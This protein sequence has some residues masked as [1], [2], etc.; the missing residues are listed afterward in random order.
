MLTL[1]CISATSLLV[2]FSVSYLIVATKDQHL[3]FTGDHCDASH[4]KLHSGSVPRVG[5]LSIAAGLLMAWVWMF[6]A[7]GEWGLTVLRLYGCLLPV[8]VAGFIEDLTGLVSPRERF[9]AAGISGGAF[10]YA[11][12]MGLSH[13]G[14]PVLDSLLANPFAS[15]ALTIFC[16]AGIS[17]ALNLVDGQNGLCSGVTTICA[18]NFGY[19]S[20]ATGQQEL[21][22]LCFAL[23]GANLGFFSVNYPSGKLFLGD[24][25][26]YL[27][28]AALGMLGILL[29][30][31]SEGG[32]SPWYGI[33]VVI[34]P[35]WETI[36]S[37]WRRKQ[38]GKKVTSPDTRHLHSLWHKLDK[39]HANLLRRSSA[40]RIWLCMLP[41][42]ALSM[43]GFQST[44]LTVGA[45]LLFI[46]IYL[47]QYSH[48]NRLS[49]RYA[50][51][52]DAT[53]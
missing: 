24:S 8:F 25:G 53:R 45:T 10:F 31:G 13:V 18:A 23:A 1:L 2:A 20:W 19:V 26:A 17:H 35:L 36:Y 39:S 48:A 4:H 42:T 44:V 16:L 34:Y 43:I 6:S 9:L 30:N 50:S 52:F 3:R 47:N 33:S 41:T 40:P 15:G 7:D 37:V 22:W 38:D 32:V 21:A 11:F 49:S 51:D 29:L 14:I 12:D 28:G 27:N 46:G 5:G